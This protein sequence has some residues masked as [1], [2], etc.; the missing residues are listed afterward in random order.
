MAY[1]W[2]DNDVYGAKHTNHLMKKKHSMAT[3]QEHKQSGCPM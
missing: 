2:Y 1:I 3:G